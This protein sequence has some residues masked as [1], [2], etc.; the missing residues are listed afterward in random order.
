MPKII[1]HID[2]DTFF[3]SSEIKLNPKFKG[4]PIAISSKQEYAMAVSISKEVKEKGFKITDKISSIKNAIPNLIV[5][6]P[7]LDY[8]RFL[9]NQFFN[10]LAKKITKKI[11]IYSIDECFIDLSEFSKNFNSVEKMLHFIKNEVQKELK[12]PISIGASYNKL[13]AKMATNLAKQFGG[14]VLLLSKSEIETLIYPQKIKNL[15]GIGTQNAQKL[16]N[17]GIITVSDFVKKGV[18]SPEIIKILGASRHYFFHSLTNLGNNKI[19]NRTQ[20]FK[21]VSHFRTFLINDELTKAK[22]L[23]FISKF[24]PNLVQKLNKYEKA[25]NKVEI[26]FKT[27]NNKLFRFFTDLVA[28][29]NNYD[30]IFLN[31]SILVN[32]IR[33][34]SEIRG[35]GIILSKISD[36]DKSTLKTKPKIKEIISEI[37]KKYDQKQIFVLKKLQNSDF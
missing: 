7:N 13:L 33:K 28:P 16:Q 11:E 30:F 20:N 22:I 1:A 27:K 19:E 5:I 21:S 37:N 29:T 3:V 2:I 14:K 36:F 32:K 9:S 12:L 34:F 26:F 18:N 10:F 24:L 35:F 4:Q 17:A 15:F 31:L 6:K 25:T 23:N 8:Y